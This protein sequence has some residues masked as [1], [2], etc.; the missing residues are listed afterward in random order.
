M[1]YFVIRCFSMETTPN[2]EKL[3][4]FGVLISKL[5]SVE[6][7]ERRDRRG[8][9]LEKRNRQTDSSHTSCQEKKEGRRET[10]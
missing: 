9:S 1:F 5:L 6:T 7:A 8:L 4:S 2:E 3:Q 10:G